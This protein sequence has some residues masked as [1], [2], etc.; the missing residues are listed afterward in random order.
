[1][2]TRTAVIMVIVA[3]I[4]LATFIFVTMTLVTKNIPERWRACS[5]GGGIPVCITV[6]SRE[7]IRKTTDGCITDDLNVICGSYWIKKDRW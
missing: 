5:T 2:T 7:Q 6:G 3:P 4:L 1:M